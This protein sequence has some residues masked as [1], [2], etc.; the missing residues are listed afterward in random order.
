MQ[1]DPLKSAW[2]NPVVATTDTATLSHLIR[3]RSSP[4]LKQIRRQ[5]V[6]E[7]LAFLTLLLVYYSAFD[8]DRKPFYLNA[9]LV[10]SVI[11]LL[12]YNL[13]GLWLTRQQNITRQVLP[14]M[15][16]Q[17][18]QLK[19]YAFLSVVLRVLGMAGIFT[20]FLL[21]VQWTTA[22]YGLL[23]LLITVMATQFYALW[24][25]WQQRIR[26]VHKIIQELGTPV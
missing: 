13:A 7:S 24:S 17:L 4:V 9:L 14:T 16:L 19:K 20:F 22:K 6:I 15:Q 2:Q 8:G 1:T 3:Q 26:R 12:L 18:Q 5:L 11:S 21:S 25:V 23:L 10:I